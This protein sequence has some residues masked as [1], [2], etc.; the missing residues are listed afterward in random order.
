[1]KNLISKISQN[2]FLIAFILVL[3]FSFANEV[4]GQSGTPVSEGIPI[5]NPILFF[6]V[7]ALIVLA[8]YFVIRFFK[9]DNKIKRK[10]RTTER[11]PIQSF[12]DGAVTKVVGKVM[13]VKNPLIAP[14]TGKK[15]VLYHAIIEKLISD[16]EV[17]NYSTIVDEKISCDFFITDKTGL[18]EIRPE[19]ATIYLKKDLKK[20][21]GLFNSM[22]ERL[23][24]YLKKHGLDSSKFLGINPGYRFQEGILEIGEGVAIS[25]QGKWEETADQYQRRDFP[26]TLVF[27]PNDQAP[28]HLSD[29]PNTF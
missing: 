11:V 21:V 15:C 5:E 2:C 7:I 25:G 1:M 3:L 26:K 27:S 16:G 29:E 8:I 4:V 17:S 19:G 6:S 13:P 10:I 9:T 24:Q 20:K 22:D 23:E 14:L 12:V 18:A 28:L